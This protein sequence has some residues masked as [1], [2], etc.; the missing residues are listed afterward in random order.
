[1]PPGEQASALVVL[2][3]AAVAAGYVERARSLAQLSDALTRVITE[4][5]ALA[6][7]A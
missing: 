5:F 1:M 4:P 2:L 3:R 7:L 6:A